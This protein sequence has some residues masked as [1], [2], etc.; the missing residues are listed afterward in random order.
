MLTSLLQLFTNQIGLTPKSKDSQLRKFTVIIK[1]IELER[2]KTAKYLD[3]EAQITHAQ[4]EKNISITRWYCKTAALSQKCD[5]F[6]SCFFFIHT[7][8]SW[9]EH[10]LKKNF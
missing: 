1:G 7:S 3:E 6:I 4:R 2:H 10:K 9:L 5:H 8:C